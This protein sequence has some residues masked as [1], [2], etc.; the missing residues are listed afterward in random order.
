MR[1]NDR[2]GR[3]IKLS[4][5]HI[6][7]AV[8]QSGSMAKAA[9]TL[10]VS[11]PVVSRSISDLERT[12]G[13]R[14]LERNP[15]GVELTEYGQALLNRSHAAFDE[16]R[17]GVKDIEFLSDPTAGEVRIGTTPPLAASFVFAVIDRLAQHYPRM[18][19]R[20]VAEG[21]SQRRQRQNLGERAVDLLIFRKVST[22]MDAQTDFEFLFDSPYVV[23]AGVSS[24]WVTRRRI[25]LAELMNESWV[26]PAP[27]DAFGSFVTDAFRAG[28]LDYPRA[29][30]I[31]SALEM[32]ANLLRTGHYLTVIP[33]F[34]LQLPDRHPFLR[35]LPVELPI[36]GAP[37]GIVTL[38]NRRPSPVV[39]H[40]IDC[41]RDVAKSL[42]KRTKQRPRPKRHVLIMRPGINSP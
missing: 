32:R 30:V 34:W 16:L 8:A 15:H 17:Q 31:T 39:N 14:L 10:A 6:L 23:A 42:G 4:D 7:V 2:I 36:A 22:V 33:E 41:A 28:G 26:L 19:F 13:V 40:F 12:L 21:T 24:P 1:W 20:V 25:A 11:H 37:I 35:K 38:K 5:L 29:T 3:R 9:S 27:E 18:V